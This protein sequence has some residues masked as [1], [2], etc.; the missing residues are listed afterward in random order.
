MCEEPISFQLLTTARDARHGAIW[1]PQES[2]TIVDNFYGLK[3][4]TRDYLLKKFPAL[5][6]GLSGILVATVPAT[7]VG[8]PGTAIPTIAP[9][10]TTSASDRSSIEA[11]SLVERAQSTLEKGVN[12]FPKPDLDQP[13]SDA[14]SEVL[15]TPTPWK[16]SDLEPIFEN[17]NEF[18]TN[19]LSRCFINGY[20]TT[21][22][23]K[24]H[25]IRVAHILSDVLSA[26]AKLDPKTSTVKQMF[27]MD[28][29]KAHSDPKQVLQLIQE[30]SAQAE[31]F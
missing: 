20:V 11:R 7:I 14:F 9:V 22:G 2:K 5:R 12:P 13:L 31:L 15:A 3:P 27:N 19:T 25:T 30:Y 29:I 4:S 28:F 23:C 1:Q 6:T 10:R 17:I 26:A 16:L 8:I 24:E 21:S 18:G